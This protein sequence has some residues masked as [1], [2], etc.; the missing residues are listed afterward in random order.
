[1]GAAA[2]KNIKIEDRMLLRH[3]NCQGRHATVG[4]DVSDTVIFLKC[5]AS[6]AFS[7]FPGILVNQANANW[8]ILLV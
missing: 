2:W 3:G 7:V 8:T 5:L 6:D 4:Y 1:M